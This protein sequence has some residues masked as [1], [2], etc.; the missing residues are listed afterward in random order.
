MDLNKQFSNLS[1]NKKPNKRVLIGKCDGNLAYKSF[2]YELCPFERGEVLAS[3]KRSDT[4]Y[5]Y[6]A[7]SSETP[8]PGDVSEQQGSMQQ[9]TVTFLDNADI[10]ILDMSSVIDTTRMQADFQDTNALGEFLSRPI[11][12]KT[13]TWTPG[14]TFNTTGFDN[15]SV[16]F[17]TMQGY[18]LKA[19]NYRLFRA[20]ALRIQF[21]VNGSPFHFG[22][23]KASYWPGRSLATA[24]VNQGNPLNATLLPTNY[25]AF[26]TTYLPLKT[27]WS[28]Y[29]GVYIDPSTN[30]VVEFDVPFFWPNDYVSLTSDDGSNNNL[31]DF[32]QLKVWELN[33]LDHANGATDPISVTVSAW[34]IEPVLT[35]PTTVTPYAGES[36]S[37]FAKMLADNDKNKIFSKKTPTPGNTTER[38]KKAKSKGGEKP[39]TGAAEGVKS[40]KNGDKSQGGDEYGKGIVSAPASALAN[41]AGTLEKV[42]VIGPYA[43]ATKVAAGYVSKIA[44]LFGYSRPVILDNQCEVVQRPFG[45]LALTSADEPLL[46]LT[47]DPKQEVTIDPVVTG[48][49][50]IDEM[51]FAY[52][53]KR[54]SLLVQVPWVALTPSGTNLVNIAIHPQTCPVNITGTDVVRFNTALSWASYP[55]LYWRGSINYRIQVVASQMHRGRLA[56]VYQPVKHAST[57]LPGSHL[58]YTQ[59]MDLTETRDCTFTVRYTHYA[60]YL[61]MHIASPNMIGSGAP[62][63]NSLISGQTNGILSIFILNELGAPT[64]TADVTIN[65]FSSAGDDFMVAGPGAVAFEQ[66]SPF[67]QF[68]QAS[69]SGE[70]STTFLAESSADY[71]VSSENAADMTQA[72]SVLNGSNDTVP[73]VDNETLVFFGEQIVSLRSLLKRYMNYRPNVWDTN[74]TYSGLCEA[75]VNNSMMPMYRGPST[76]TEDPAGNWGM[77][78]SDLNGSYNFVNNTLISWYRF[79]YAGWRGSLRYKIIFDYNNSLQQ[80]GSVYVRRNYATTYTT[81]QFSQFVD[82]DITENATSTQAQRLASILDNTLPS[83]G[84]TDLSFMY[85][86]NGIEYEVPYYVPQR[87][88][89]NRLPAPTQTNTEDPNDSYYQNEYAMAHSVH[90]VYFYGRDT[91]FEAVNNLLTTTWVATGEDFSLHYFMAAPIVG[92]T[93]PDITP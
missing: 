3:R 48:L 84:G 26:N 24:Y 59:Y 60:P 37:S 65:I 14:A 27:H 1:I 76:V 92:F 82:D 16:W 78:I 42:P 87:F 62:S 45:S 52:L 20:K 93:E 80:A 25:G 21:R 77:G 4:P 57:A 73:D 56:V 85:I 66:L 81:N 7:E 11:R 70:S 86:K 6:E 30:D 9:E 2:R 69:Y 22:K 39:V 43:T 88:V 31:T 28:Q 35:M 19:T 8:L 29:P 15:I 54:E 17:D 10:K 47:L 51:S 23:L 33:E 64:N 79:G 50:E 55:F 12:L 90:Q 68:M 75:T 40:T 67:T 89:W 41:F 72:L 44:K 71:K 5:P 74:N 58:T 34:F 46:K 83:L 49:G 91:W 32:G 18:L 38:T 13:Y 53:F 61:A 36:S 63:F